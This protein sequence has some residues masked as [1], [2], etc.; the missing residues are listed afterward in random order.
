MREFCLRVRQSG[1]ARES[2]ELKGDLVG[3]GEKLY[4]TDCAEGQLK[5]DTQV[6]MLGSTNHVGCAS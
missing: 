3:K 2:G 5:R 4:N 1:E 6:A